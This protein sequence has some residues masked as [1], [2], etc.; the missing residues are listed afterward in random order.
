MSTL[1][2]LW[3]HHNFGSKASIAVTTTVPHLP[4]PDAHFDLVYAIS[5]FTHI[6]LTFMS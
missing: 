4:F 6:D 1:A 5:I 2:A 3:A